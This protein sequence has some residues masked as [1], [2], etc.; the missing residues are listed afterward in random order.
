MINCPSRKLSNTAM[1][2]PKFD[3]S[4]LVN[5]GRHKNIQA[6]R[7]TGTSE[8][9]VP[10]RF[11]DSTDY[12]PGHCNVVSYDGHQQSRRMACVY[13]ECPFF[14]GWCDVVVMPAQAPLVLID[15][16]QRHR[17][18]TTDI[19]LWPSSANKPR[20]PRHRRTS[21]GSGLGQ[22]R[23]TAVDVPAKECKRSSPG[24]GPQPKATRR[25]DRSRRTTAPLNVVKATPAQ[26]KTDTLSLTA[27]SASQ[28]GQE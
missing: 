24:A 27:V 17:R 11:I 10:A 26:N 16:V 4:C 2:Q 19:P 5:V 1:G 25:V 15:N 23:G 22:H 14:R 13:M 21:T 3:P 28:L 6:V 9:F 12:I 18:A 7:D 20:G 8:L